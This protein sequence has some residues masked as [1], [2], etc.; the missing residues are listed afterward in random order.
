MERQMVT[1]ATTIKNSV[2]IQP[3]FK[4][5]LKIFWLGDNLI[6]ISVWVQWNI[7]RGLC[8]VR[9]TLG[10]CLLGAYL[11]KALFTIRTIWNATLITIRPFRDA[12][13]FSLIWVSIRLDIHV[14]N[15]TIDTERPLTRCIVELASMNIFFRKFYLQRI[16]NLIMVV[17]ALISESTTSGIGFDEPRVC[18][19]ASTIFGS[20]H[21]LGGDEELP[22]QDRHPSSW[23]GHG[24]IISGRLCGVHG[25]CSSSRTVG[26]RPKICAVGLFIAHFHTHLLLPNSFFIG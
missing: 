8:S 18:N 21:I 22:C 9:R 6:S 19:H 11:Y 12:F 4:T 25:V 17:V 1:A 26:C 23:Y 15:R 5:T 2:I 24:T 16:Q 13:G 20:Q 14:Y 7:A 10:F 3:W